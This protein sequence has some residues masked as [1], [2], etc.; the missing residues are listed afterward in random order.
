MNMKIHSVHRF[1]CL[2]AVHGFL[3]NRFWK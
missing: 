3:G 1:L 2:G